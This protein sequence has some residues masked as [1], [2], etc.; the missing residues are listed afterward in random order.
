MTREMRTDIGCRFPKL[1]SYSHLKCHPN[2]INDKKVGKARLSDL[3]AMQAV[4]DP[5]SPGRREAPRAPPPLPGSASNPSETRVSVIGCCG[6]S[7]TG[8]ARRRAD[9]DLRRR[10]QASRDAR[11]GNSGRADYANISRADAEEPRHPFVRVCLAPRSNLAYRVSR[12]LAW[13]PPG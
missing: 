3:R 8:Y 6:W 12:R 13:V 9:I 2:V 10:A 4:E 11:R 1:M 7:S 5:R